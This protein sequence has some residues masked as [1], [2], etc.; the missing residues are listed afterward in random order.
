MS[1]STPTAEFARFATAFQAISHE[2]RQRLLVLLQERERSVG[3][4][5][6]EFELSQPT[7]SRHLGVLKRAGFVKDRRAGQQVFYSLD[8]E[9]IRT[10]CVEFFSRFQ[11]CAPLVE[12][13]QQRRPKR[14]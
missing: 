13:F 9:G 8:E 10:C 6:E 2:V 1:A 4:L 11:C 12:R 3:E 7:I 5:V 14:A